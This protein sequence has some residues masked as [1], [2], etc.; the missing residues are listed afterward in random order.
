MNKKD[1]LAYANV[2]GILLAYWGFKWCQQLPALPF[3]WLSSALLHLHSSHQA[4]ADCKLPNSWAVE[5][6]ENVCEREVGRGG[7]RAVLATIPAGVYLLFTDS[8]R[9]T[10]LNMSP[11]PQ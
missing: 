10:A 5:Q 8:N 1:V 3:P 11:R 2:P 4:D 6:R 7:R 9:S